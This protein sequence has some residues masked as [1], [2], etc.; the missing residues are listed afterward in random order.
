MDSTSSPNARR[1]ADGRARAAEAHGLS[2][3]VRSRAGRDDRSDTPLAPRAAHPVLAWESWIGPDGRA[4]WIGPG[5]ERATGFTAAECRAMS[6]YPLPLALAAE[7]S[8]LSAARADALNDPAGRA[9]SFSLRGRDGAL[10]P[11]VATWHC[12][13]DD[14]G[15][16][17]GWRLSIDVPAGEPVD[18]A[19]R[20]AAD[21]RAWFEHAPLAA[22]LL[23]RH[24]AILHANRAFAGLL[25]RGAAELAG[26]FVQDYVHPSDAGRDPLISFDGVQSA[27]APLRIEKRFVQRDGAAF[28][29]RMT[30]VPAADSA[31]GAGQLLAALED[32]SEWHALEECLRDESALRDAVI[33]GAA[34]GLCVFHARPDFP[35]VYFTIW[36][37]RMEAITGYS[38]D[39]VNRR[40]WFTLTY[41]APEDAAAARERLA[42]VSAGEHMHDSEWPIRCR[43]GGLRTVAISTSTLQVIDGVPHIL[44]AMLDVTER[45]QAERALRERAR[46]AAVL[47]RIGCEA[48]AS[49]SAES[50]ITAALDALP[51]VV[52]CEL[53]QFYVLDGGQLVLRGTRGA[54]AAPDP[55]ALAA[56][57]RALDL[58][59][60]ALERRAAQY[61]SGGAAGA[62]TD[63]GSGCAALPL[64]VGES[65]LGVILLRSAPAYDWRSQ[66]TFLET[67]AN[68]FAAALQNALKFESESR[69]ATALADANER[70]RT[71]FSERVRVEEKLRQNQAELARAARLATLGE[72]TTGIAHEINQPLSVI[73]S[74]AEAGI[75]ALERRAPDAAELIG[76]LGHIA[77][78]AE[79]AG[80]IIRRLRKMLGRTA[81]KRSTLD[82]HALLRELSELILPEARLG[83]TELEFDLAAEQRFVQGDSIGLSQVFLNLL[84]NALDSVL[85]SAAGPRRIRISTVEDPRHMLEITIA[86]TGGQAPPDSLEQMFELFFTR[87]PNGLGVGLAISRRIVTAHGGRLW[88]ENNP[89][90]GL[91]LRMT[92]PLSG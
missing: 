9:V 35:Y 41:S 69:I 82:V 92:L 44:A 64:W 27:A 86:D 68:T 52:P 61:D 59:R 29:A 38:Q 4:W 81:E 31:G 49:L 65:P 62:G 5:V 54:A 24:G 53:M 15:A 89:G 10:R 13:R 74:R 33:H 42:R 30:V 77:A 80:Q 1:S 3:D 91:S 50:V 40:G 56:S 75:L 43:G 72:L 37:P 14:D 2:H 57:Q 36:N 6:D 46:E 78:A 16:F 18:S 11:A 25:G 48:N 76:D 73:I 63:Q 19:Q 22:A 45:T 66:A 23:D 8:E 87:K 28:Q 26:R 12:L 88:A 71:E 20:G 84:R 85:E 34:E 39:E 32:V 55:D 17:R 51:L 60:L 70:I 7:R 83:S 79:R 47:Y 21:A 90:P 58:G 67:V